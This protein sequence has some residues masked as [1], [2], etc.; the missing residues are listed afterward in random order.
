M[1]NEMAESVENASRSLGGKVGAEGLEA[2]TAA[3][4]LSLI[5]SDGKK[6]PLRRSVLPALPLTRSLYYLGAHT[7]FA[8]KKGNRP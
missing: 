7:Q 1:R 3:V 8:L 4:C 2:L 6:M 5:G